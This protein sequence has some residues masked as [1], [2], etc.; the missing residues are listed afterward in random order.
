MDGIHFEIEMYHVIRTTISENRLFRFYKFILGIELSDEAL[1][2]GQLSLIL[3]RVPIPVEDLLRVLSIFPLPMCQQS[4]MNPILPRHLTEL[5]T[6]DD[7]VDRRDLEF[8]GI[9]FPR[10]PHGA[11]PCA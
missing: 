5:A 3:V 9:C 1:A 6:A 2:L 4:G 8:P 7:L 11:P 10:L